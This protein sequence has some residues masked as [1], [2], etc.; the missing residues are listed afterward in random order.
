MP[1]DGGVLKTAD[2]VSLELVE[3]T[4]ISPDSYLLK[5]LLPNGLTFGVPPGNHAWLKM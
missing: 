1:A 4:L 3:K 5:F 2:S